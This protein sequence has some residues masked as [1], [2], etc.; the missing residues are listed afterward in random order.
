MHWVIL[1]TALLQYSA[2]HFESLWFLTFVAW[3]PWIH[4]CMKHN[5]WK[6]KVWVSFAVGA[7]CTIG[8]YGLPLHNV[9]SRL[10]LSFASSLGL[11][12]GFLLFGNF[13]F[14]LASV[15][16]SRTKSLLFL[17]V[18]YV[19]FEAVIPH[20]FAEKIGHWAYPSDLISQLAQLFGVSGISFLMMMGNV[21]IYHTLAAS[22]PRLRVQNSMVCLLLLI[23]AYGYGAYE[24][25]LSRSPLT[26]RTVSVLGVFGQNRDAFESSRGMGIDVYNQAALRHFFSQT[27]QSLKG[28][29]S[30]QLVIW[31]ES[32]IPFPLEEKSSQM[33]AL[34]NLAKQIHTP[35]LT[36]GFLRQGPGFLNAYFSVTEESVRKAGAKMNLVPIFETGQFKAEKRAEPTTIGGL[37]LGVMICYDGQIPSVSRAYAEQ[38]VDLIV[39][40][41]DNSSMLGTP[42]ASHQFNFLKFRAIE[43]RTPV[44]HLSTAGVSGWMDP[45]GR[46]REQVDSRKL[47]AQ[48]LYSKR[49]QIELTSQ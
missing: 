36:G 38:K 47:S 35:I 19:F 29:D 28:Q 10:D 23:T 43:N 8:F 48:D 41:S 26:Q 18:A 9:Q 39:V 12:I 32:A 17:P 22:S 3:V 25:H 30:I 1:W 7:I 45:L 16:I 40:L 46:V 15:L 14:V 49:F 13:Q 5:D 33:Q 11:W 42:L 2:V 37:R 21:C 31:P 44:L 34:V 24:M 4:F 20:L 27:L 6:L